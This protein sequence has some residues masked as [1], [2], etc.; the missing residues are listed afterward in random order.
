[1]S[2]KNG[3]IQVEYRDE[4]EAFVVVYPPVDDGEPAQYKECVDYLNAH[5]FTDFD[6]QE[7]RRILNF[8]EKAEMSLGVGDG[9]EFIESMSVK[10]S[11]DKMKVTC[12]FY[13]PSTKGNNLEVKDIIGELSSKSVNFG[14]DQDLILAFIEDRVYFTDF[15]IANGKPPRHGLDDKIEYFF[16]TNP[17]LKPKHND[18]GSVDYHSLNTI[19]HVNEGD[20]IARLHKGDRGE[21]GKDVSGKEI[22]CRSVKILK[23][24]TGKN[25][26]LSE[27]LL[28]LYSEATGHVSLVNGKVFVSDV[29]EVPAD[30]DNSVG[31]IEY[32][33]NVHV[34]GS[35]RGGF[36]IIAKGDVIVD[37]VVED[38]LIQAEGQII[39]KCGIHG[40]Q[41]GILD[42]GGNVVTKFIENAKVFSGGYVEAGNITHSDVSAADDVIVSEQ[43]GAI[44]GGI[45]R[46]GGKVDAQTLGSS[47]GAQTIIEVGMAPEK[48]ERYVQLQREITVLSQNINKLRPIIK[49]YNSYVTAGKQL[50]QKNAL[51]LQRIA[52]ELKK[53][54]EMLAKDQEEFNELHQELITSRH[55][56]VLVRKD[57]FSGVSITISDVSR[58][59]NDKRSYCQF[60][61]KNG[62]VVVSN[63]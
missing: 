16:N 4:N 35:V 63:L 29:Y 38:A 57:V 12:R 18:D 62:E 60:E 46:A 26:R 61:K 11:L 23:L 55:A 58:M 22:P 40:M 15:I 44:T 9:L 50:D 14:V 52:T 21:S 7:F 19:C 53:N 47:M 27:D 1:M 8:G 33:G 42:A 49:T 6:V 45:T 25:M 2:Q 17:T 36:S 34:K 24:E 5:G 28:E 48:K 3:Y 37:G 54:T 59:V 10:I 41:K 13:P 43:K 20:L 32:N 39:V 30:V 51:Y 31:N 56:K